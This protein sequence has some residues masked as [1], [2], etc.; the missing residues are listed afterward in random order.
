MAFVQL[1]DLNTTLE[2]V[3]F[4]TIYKN[5]QNFWEPDA[6]V[7]AEGK[8]NDKD[9][10]VKI[11]VDKVWPLE[12][13]TPTTLPPLAQSITPALSRNNIPGKTPTATKLKPRQFTIELPQR[14]T[15]KT[16][17]QLKLM[18][19]DHPGETAVELRIT[20]G[21]STKIVQTSLRVQYTAELEE[22]VQ[23]LLTNV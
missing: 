15:K 3:V 9:G 19:L 23:Q 2:L 18:L 16:I 4:P 1:E 13:V 8:V 20:H 17:E 22:K 21:G 11:L 10:S 12:A 6:T 5:Y 14:T 7:L